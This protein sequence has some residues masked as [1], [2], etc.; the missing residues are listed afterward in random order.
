[1][2]IVDAHH[3]IWQMKN[4]PWLVGEPVPRIF[5]E[6]E[7]IRRDYPIEEYLT[8]IRK[9]GMSKTVYVQVNWIPDQELHDTRWEQGVANKFDFPNAIDGLAHLPH[10]DVESIFAG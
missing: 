6:Y 10:S 3:H 4:L 2:E 8:D 7:S 1:M 9:W 5:G